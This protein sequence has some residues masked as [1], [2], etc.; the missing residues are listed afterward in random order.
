[1]GSRG[2][3]QGDGGPLR[4][5][6]SRSRRTSCARR[7]ASTARR[8]SRS[9]RRTRATVRGEGEGA[10]AQPRDR[11]A[12]DARRRALRDPP[13]RR[14]PLARAPREH[15]LPARG[16]PPAR[17]GPEGPA[18]RVH[19]RGPGDV[20]GAERRDPRGGRDDALPRADRGRG[21]RAAAA[22]AGGAGA[23]RRGFAYEHE[24]LAGA[25]AIAAAGGGRRRCGDG[26]SVT[27]GALGAGGGAVATQ[28]RVTRDARRSAATT[29]AGAAAARS[30]SAATARNRS[31]PAS[32]PSGS[33]AAMLSR[34]GVRP[35]GRG[36]TNGHGR[37]QLGCTQR[38]FL[39]LV[40]GRPG[41]RAGAKDTS[42]WG[43]LLRSLPSTRDGRPDGLQPLDQQLQEIGAQL[44]WVRDYL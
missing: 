42:L 19:H 16:R 28:Q 5:R 22:G 8:S 1:M 41:F 9:S 33:D 2:A 31:R 12:A 26:A 21:R 3:L 20:R 39:P 29:R 32:D 17:D 7:S 30:S 15:G 24:S 6:A 35:P 4:D 25:E 38:G 10:R 34:S 13:G 11:P 14:H 44:A 37:W 40:D 23:R 18:R 43:R 27:A 36:P